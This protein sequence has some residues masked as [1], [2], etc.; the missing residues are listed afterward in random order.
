MVSALGANGG[1]DMITLSRTRSSRST[2][3]GRRPSGLLG[4]AAAVTVAAALVATSA[5]GAAADSARTIAVVD[6]EDIALSGAATLSELL[7]SRT[8]FN[9]FGRH[10]ALMGTGS[11]ITLVNG[12]PVSG[13]DFTTLPLAA[14]E[15]VEILDQGP[16]R[17]SA[18]AIGRTLNIVL[19]ND[20]DGL[21][22]SAGI[23]LPTREG[24]DSRNGSALWGG[25]L[26]RGHMT[27]AA[28][29]YGRDELR[30]RDRHFTRTRYTPGGSIADAQGV[31]GSGNTV[32]LPKDAADL[33]GRFGLGACS[34]PTYTGILT[35][36]GG[37]VCGLPVGDI[38]WLRGE[39]SRESLQLAADHPLDD[40]AD[41]YVEAR[42]AQGEDFSVSTP[43]SDRFTFQP[44][45]DARQRLLDNVINLPT[46]YDLPA[47]GEVTLFHSFIGH[48]NR[49]WTT[50]LEEHALTLGVQGEPDD[51]L[52]YDVHVEYHKDEEVET[53][54]NLQS[55]SLVTAAIE[56]GAYD[57]VN[58]LSR[59][60]AHL[61]AIRDTAI[62]STVV[63]ENEYTKA[64]A[65]L[66]GETLTMAGGAL[67]WT[68]GVGIED[69]AHRYVF[70]FRDN[71]NISYEND[72]VI[73]YGGASLVA[74]RF[75]WSMF[76][77]ST[78]PLLEGWDL[79]LG[80][81]RD[82]YDD[83]GEAVSLHATNRYRLN[84]NLA[85]RTSWSRAAHP[86][87]LFWVHSPQAQYYTPVCDPLL[88]NDDGGP[89][90][91]WVQLI[92]GGNPDLE[93]AQME[94][95]SVGA[96]TTFGGFS[97]SADWFSVDDTD[98]PAAPNF[99][100][101]VD[102]AAAGNPLPDTSVERSAGDNSIE[103]IIA[104][105]GPFKETEARGVALHAGADWETDWADFALDV[106]ATRT[107]HY[108]SIVLDVEDPGG[109][110]RDRAHAV[111]QARRGDIAARWSVYGRSGFLNAIET[112]R[113]KAWYGH[114]L[115]LQWRDLLGMGLDLAGGVL[116]VAN[117]DASLDSSG[118]RGAVTSYDSDRGRTFFLNATMT[119]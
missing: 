49:E 84:D 1:N 43:N 110:V 111:L 68:V 33:G 94:R 6:R 15:R 107:L 69:W 60:P 50:K 118:D 54:V 82:D 115:T 102:R 57:F 5:P 58:P 31:S 109:Y 83:V 37:E 42:V 21:E 40:D 119:W 108:A 39:M 46:G 78:L 104:P 97:F 66:E 29:H 96:T 16:V 13:V 24:M 55:N 30:A 113:Y 34:E 10:G 26:G 36:P 101:L 22:V 90:C 44:T 4:L 72:D 14:V 75:R 117:R 71:R 87:G 9:V 17:H 35:H 93:P 45:G 19:R 88:K 99:Q 77:E 8:V 51:A 70:D 47:D 89:L 65:S 85:F 64:N 62:R 73:G 100:I 23:G 79:T 32:I 28:A 3:S 7:S 2:V 95:F 92:A 12:R 25:A 38:Y 112:G 81:R 63:T 98:L 80:A 67:R 114:D 116:N 18:Y 91:G 56:S 105:T 76:A 86:P 59:A 74:D 103:R 106:H 11:A 61:Q 52:G 20:F 27:A 41:V 53:G 48:G